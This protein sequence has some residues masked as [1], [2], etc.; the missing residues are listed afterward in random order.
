MN[1]KQALLAGSVLALPAVAQAQPISGLYIGAGA[2][3]G[4]QYAEQNKG[5]SLPNGLN[6]YVNRGA[7]FDA[8]WTGD[9]NL[10]YGFGN[11]LRAEVEAYVARNELSHFSG[12]SA[13]DGFENKHGGMVNLLYDIDVASWGVPVLQPYVG[14]GVGYMWV[15][16]QGVY[17]G[18][19]PAQLQVQDSAATFAY[20]G[21][22]G[23]AIPISAVPGLAA[24]V[25]YRAMAMLRDRNYD[26]VIATKAGTRTNAFSGSL[27]M[28]DEVAQSLMF[29]LRYAFYTPPPPP[30]PAPA[31]VAAPAPA[32]SRTYLVFFDWDKADLTERARQIIAEAAQNVGR[33]QV[34]RI[35]VNGY[36]DT[37][38][39][40]AYNQKLSVRRAQNV[41]AELV[42]DGVPQNEITI[43]GFGDTH[44]LV[45][46]GPG[47]REPQNRR[48]EIILK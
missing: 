18:L 38:G 43:Q 40:P 35:E 22:V 37:S 31:P 15:N 47:V 21:I 36:T 34:T 5:F 33:V 42:K 39:K 4:F 13:G 16:W 19:P 32:P 41:A 23:V 30:P 10:G 6:P 9:F 28:K 46:T 45:P 27:Q 48:V 17:A 24:T 44:L 2:G 14:V 3:V 26:G 12:I 11:G 25:D 20:Q 29:G 7:H 8:G 1:V